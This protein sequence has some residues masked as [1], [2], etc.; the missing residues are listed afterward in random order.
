MKMGTANGFEVYSWAQAFLIWLKLLNII[1]WTW[2]AVLF[3][4]YFLGVEVLIVT[5][6]VIVKHH[7]QQKPKDKQLQ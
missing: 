6:G 7:A 4:T 1:E 3:P 5:I 2:H